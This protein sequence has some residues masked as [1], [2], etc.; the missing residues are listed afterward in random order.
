MKTLIIGDIHG[1][2]FELMDLVEKS[3]IST[4]DQIIALGDL[5]D[6]GPDSPAVIDFFRSTNTRSVMG[7]HEQKH[8]RSFRGEIEPAVGQI[9]ARKQFTG[10]C[11]LSTIDFITKFPDWLELTEA[12][13]V[14]GLIEPGIAL[15]A[16]HPNILNGTISGEAYMSKKYFKP[17]YEIYHG[18]KPVIAGHHDYSQAG[19][20][21]IYKDLVYLIDTGCCYGRHLTGILLPEFK[22]FSTKSSKNYW[23]FARQSYRKNFI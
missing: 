17:W 7:N 6:R 12:I 11:Y 1:C 3:G 18:T 15:E 14:H 8:I 20:P 19:K 16:Q 21:T 10:D 23:T 5:M 2:Y 13:L 4:N 9:I 22:I